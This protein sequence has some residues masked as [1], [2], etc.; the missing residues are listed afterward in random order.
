MR[1]PQRVAAPPAAHVLVDH[2][3]E[4]DRLTQGLAQ[5]DEERHIRGMQLDGFGVWVALKQRGDGLLGI[6]QLRCVGEKGFDGA[7]ILWVQTRFGALEHLLEPVAP[8][9]GQPRAARGGGVG[10][11]IAVADGQLDVATQPLQV[12]HLRHV[13]EVGL[14]GPGHRGDDLV[15][16]GGDGIRVTGDLVEQ[17]TAPRGAV[18]DL[19]DVGAELATAGSHAALGFS[20]ADPLV[21]ALGFDQHPLDRRRGGRLQRGHR[22]GADQNAVDRHQRETVFLRPATGQVFRGAL[23]RADAAADADGDV[24]PRPQLGVGRQQQVVEVFPRMV[25]TGSAAFDVHDHRLGGHLRGDAD[26]RADLL[27]GPGLEHDV[28]DPDVVELFDQLDGFLQ[29]RDAG[30]DDDAVDC[31][32][33]LTGLLHQPLAAQLQLPQIGVEEQGVELIGATGVEQSG[34]FLDAV[35]K[36]LLGDLAATGQLGPVPRIGGR[37]DDLGVHSGRCH[38][39]QQDRRPAGEPGELRRKLHPAV[40]KADHR[41]GIARPGAGDLRGGSDGEQVALTAAGGRGHDADA[42][43]A[44]DRGGEAGQDVA[45]TEVE[46]PPGARVVHSG[47]LVDPIDLVNQDRVGELPRQRDIEAH[48]LRP[49]ADDVDA[50]GQPGG[51]EAHLDL[52]RIEKGRED[53]A[54]ADFVLAVGFFL[55]RDLV[56]VKLEAG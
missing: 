36:D 48:L 53:V 50:V 14:G 32:A 4:I 3:H 21:G 6:L 31:R 34:Q 12:G 49:A 30:T 56:A 35:G 55:L 37:G 1:L 24:G 23:G 43:P 18:V 5:G 38:A 41:R 16:S 54:A 39:G 27:D 26:H 11:G 33:G 45:G 46:N 17:L 29:V 2:R 13:A 28:A 52:H 42:Q 20:G 15:T 19:V 44:D 7:G 47:D 10:G 22:R 25:S 8:G 40:G 51:V 9:V